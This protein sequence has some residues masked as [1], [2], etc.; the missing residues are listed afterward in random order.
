MFQIDNIDVMWNDVNS[1]DL[2]IIISLIWFLI[3]FNS[4][5]FPLC[6]PP[7]EIQFETFYIIYYHMKYNLFNSFHLLL[8][9]FVSIVPLTVHV[10][11]PFECFPHIKMFSL[12]NFN[13]HYFMFCWVEFCWVELCSFAYL[14]PGILQ[15]KHNVFSSNS[16]W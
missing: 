1:F 14:S 11:H 9:S 16:W 15:V 3:C 10:P 6:H 12:L 4:F 8:A 7:N 2:I 13:V 5:Y